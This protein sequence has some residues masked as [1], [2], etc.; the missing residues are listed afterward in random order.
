MVVGGG[1]GGVYDLK[2]GEVGLMRL[3]LAG[4]RDAAQGPAANCLLAA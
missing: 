3:G 4:T 1:E 2:V